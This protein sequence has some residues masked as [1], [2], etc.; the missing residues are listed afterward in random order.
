[1]IHSGYMTSRR[2][3]AL[4]FVLV[5]GGCGSAKAA[6]PS[7]PEPTW[8]R[9]DLNVL[10]GPV[11]GGTASV[12]LAV[13][14]NDQKA[15]DLVA[16][17]AETGASIWR[18]PTS[19][20]GEKPDGHLIRPVVIGDVVVAPQEFEKSDDL[21]ARNVNTGSE[22]WRIPF[23]ELHQPWACGKALLCVNGLKDSELGYKTL[24]VIDPQTGNVKIDESDFAGHGFATDDDRGVEVSGANLTVARR[25]DDGSRWKWQTKLTDQSVTDF[26]GAGGYS[27]HE[28]KTTMFVTYTWDAKDGKPERNAVAAID[29]ESGR[30]LWTR[31][32]SEVVSSDNAE[33][34]AYLKVDG[35]SIGVDVLTGKE[36]WRISQNLDWDHYGWKD[37]TSALL[38]NADDKS[39]IVVTDDGK[40]AKP[41]GNQQWWFFNERSADLRHYGKTETWKVR[42]WNSAK[43][44]PMMNEAPAGALQPLPKHGELSGWTT[45]VDKDG[46]LFAT[47][48]DPTSRTEI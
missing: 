2:I 21:V 1:M 27:F 4:V 28:I 20:S 14:L 48:V 25:N 24:E 12:M 23:W 15:L 16:L 5:L 22:L 45:R 3:L 30:I 29:S 44:F 11:D 38:Q 31:D 8:S 10:A 36:K 35:A 17:N 19:A 6:A 37:S 43:T 47:P 32:H 9:Q 40:A 13:V 39:W 18:R 41:S 7:T 46:H 26:S 33:K 42:G 34:T